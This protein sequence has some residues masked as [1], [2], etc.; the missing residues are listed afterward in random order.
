MSLLLSPLPIVLP[1][2]HSTSPSLPQCN[3]RPYKLKIPSSLVNAR[4]GMFPLTLRRVHSRNSDQGSQDT[5]FDLATSYSRSSV[6]H[7]HHSFRVFDFCIS[8]SLFRYKVIVANY[9]INK[10]Q[11]NMYATCTYMYSSMSV[12]MLRFFF[13]KHKLLLC[14]CCV[15]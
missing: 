9:N 8:F 7:T 6:C 4:R 1:S 2:P 13:I 11:H 5:R 15:T 10:R 3:L 12:N 14:V